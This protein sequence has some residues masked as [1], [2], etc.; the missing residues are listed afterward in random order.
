VPDTDPHAAPRALSAGLTAALLAWGVGCLCSEPLA[1]AG[2]AAA[3]ALGVA[4]AFQ[5]GRIDVRVLLRDGW[6]LWLFLAWAVLAPLVAGRTPSGSGLARLSDWAAIPIA[7]WAL[8]QV[9]PRLKAVLA[10]TFAVVFLV[11]CG[12]AGL[13]HFGVWPP[14]SFFAP[15]AWTRM[16]FYRVYEP[17]PGDLGRYMGGGLIFHRLKFAHVGGIAVVCAAA[18]G[19]RASGRWRAAG[20]ATAGSGF[21]SILVF[22]YARAAAVALAGG[23]VV[24]FAL[25]LPNRRIGLAVGGVLLAVAA[26][27]VGVNAP[28]R[29]RFLNGVTASGSGDRDLLLATGVAAVREHPLVGAG[30]GRFRPSLYAPPGSPQHVLEQ[31]GKAHNELLSMAAETGIPGALIFAGLLVWL[32]RRMRADRPEGVAALG[33]L[34]YFVL[35]SQVHDPL[36]QA[37][38]SMAL[39]LALGA[40]LTRRS[41]P[42]QTAKPST[43]AS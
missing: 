40:G 8:S 21:A 43:P 37:P 4:N 33:V 7:A 30:L 20:L 11:S 29:Q 13:Q 38:F 35:L 28:L 24:A 39:A 12:V 2:I 9:P 15:L 1:S 27:A 42:S 6:P 18:L 31:P 36:F 10:A 14:E 16:P 3:A 32:A 22:P 5:R 25:G 23:L 19:L 34:A 41:E 26:I 17:V